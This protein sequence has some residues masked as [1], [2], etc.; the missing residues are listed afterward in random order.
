MH[1]NPDSS[2]PSYTVACLCDV[3]QCTPPSFF[4]L[5]L[6]MLPSLA[7]KIVLNHMS[8]LASA[9]L[10]PGTWDVRVGRTEGQDRV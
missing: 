6:P 3:S 9:G 4:R 5:I 10:T 7:T 2:L 1:E 8:P